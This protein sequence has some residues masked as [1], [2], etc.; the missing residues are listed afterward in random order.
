V[1]KLLITRPIAEAVLDQARACFDVTLG[2][3]ALSEDDAAL[4]LTA[5]DAILPTL[6]DAFTAGAFDKAG[7]PRARILGNFGVG[8]NHIDVAAATAAGVVV[9]NTPDVLT[10]ATADIGWT[11][12]LA[13]A[14]R[15]GEGERMVRAGQW[16][17]FGPQSLL[18]TDV[19]GKVL[20]VVG[21]GRI[22]Q[23][24]A[25]RGHYGFGM[26]VIYHNRSPK[27]AGLPARQVETLHELMAQADFVV[28]TVPGG[29][30][31]TGLIDAD[32]LAAMKPGGIFVNI[33]RGEVVDEAA[34]IAAL[35]QG[36]IAGA[37]LDVYAAEPHV[38]DRLRA[39]DNCVLLPHLGSAT[40][41]TRQAMGR[42]ALDNIIAFVEG[43]DPPQRVN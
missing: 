21:M 24:V 41:E 18:G 1:L 33:S 42:M 27:D 9:T 39:L 43:R 30:G 6:G 20:G 34:L 37:G 3:A 36:T 14:R 8:Y 17:G 7:A 22:G 35:E 40:V 16:G 31:T 5:Y 12:I 19:T 28:V 23:A 32:A 15:A 4:A 25:R 29:A 26:E 38:P 2:E 10:D 13:T 11:L